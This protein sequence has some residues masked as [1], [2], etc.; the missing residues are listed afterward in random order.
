MKWLSKIWREVRGNAI[1]DSIK[2]IWNSEVLWKMLSAIMAMLVTFVYNSWLYYKDLQ[3]TLLQSLIMFVGLTLLFLLI[4]WI[5]RPR[6]VQEISEPQPNIVC[7]KTYNDR[8]TSDLNDQVWKRYSGGLEAFLIDFGNEPIENQKVGELRSVTATI[9]FYNK[10]GDVVHRTHDGI[11][12][13][14]PGSV[15]FPTSKVQSLL[16]T[17]NVDIGFMRVADR[18]NRESLRENFYNVEVRLTGDNQWLKTFKFELKINKNKQANL[19][20]VS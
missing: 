4:L 13:D 18:Q 12:L 6:K 1:W 9:F 2:W 17:Y 14:T 11:W 5:F 3:I 19:I 20:W 16:I 7:L 10:K 8:V 15:W